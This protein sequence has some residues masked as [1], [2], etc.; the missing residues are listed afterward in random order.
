[1]K[2]RIIFTV[3]LLV[4]VFSFFSFFQFIRPSLEAQIAT[5][6]LSDSILGYELSK[7]LV[8][9]DLVIY[10]TKFISVVVL[11]FIWVPVICNKIKN[12]GVKNEESD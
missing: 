2:T 1:M 7:K 9:Q 8:S 12:E 11:A 3:I 4:G 5:Y 10:W 6:Q